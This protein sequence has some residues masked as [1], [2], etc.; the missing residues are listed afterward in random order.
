MT[1]PAGPIEDVPDYV[2]QL[3]RAERRARLR[4]R[5]IFVAVWVVLLATIVLGLAVTGNIDLA[6]IA[7]NAPFIVG[8]VWITIIVC[9]ASIAL[10][11]RGLSVAATIPLAA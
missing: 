4:F 3:A 5:F 6:F 7:E 1:A 10:A 8:G 9:V 2:E 11:R